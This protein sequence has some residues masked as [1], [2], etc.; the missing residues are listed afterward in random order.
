MHLTQPS[1]TIRGDRCPERPLTHL[2]QHSEHDDRVATRVDAGAQQLEGTA[3]GNRK[4]LRQRI[5]MRPEEFP[6][7]AGVQEQ[8]TQPID[9]A[10]SKL[11]L[12]STF[13]GLQVTRSGLGFDTHPPSRARHQRI[14]RTPVTGSR[15]THFGA[16][17]KRAME[18]GPEARQET[19]VNG[20]PERLA[21][22]IRAG[23]E[24]ETD[25]RR[26]ARAAQ[27]S[28]DAGVVE[29]AQ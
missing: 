11:Q 14:P 18:L 17:S 7:V 2:M 3:A 23:A 8:Q 5:P 13:Q 22:W 9:V 27:P 28:V 29:L 12:K 20:V 15:E 24:R 6:V 26:D 4:A 10:V 16:V 1:D 21:I 19:R 25:G